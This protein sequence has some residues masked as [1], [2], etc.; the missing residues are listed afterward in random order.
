MVEG[1]TKQNITVI[2]FSN[3]I[4]NTLLI[5]LKLSVSCRLPNPSQEF[6]IE[7]FGKGPKIKTLYIGYSK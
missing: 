3:H 6:G 1:Q 5:E 7:D 2:P 4:S